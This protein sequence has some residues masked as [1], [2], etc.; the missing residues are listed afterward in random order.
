MV[1]IAQVMRVHA[2]EEIRNPGQI[3]RRS[4]WKGRRKWGNHLVPLIFSVEAS[5][6]PLGALQSHGLGLQLGRVSFF[7]LWQRFNISHANIYLRA[8]NELDSSCTESPTWNTMAWFSAVM[9]APSPSKK[10]I[11][12]G[13]CEHQLCKLHSEGCRVSDTAVSWS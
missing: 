10:E 6:E 5:N 4:T 13:G 9:N 2:N 12:P 11:E 8:G 7:I 3:W 1:L